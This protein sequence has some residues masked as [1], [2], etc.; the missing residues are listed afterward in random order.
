MAETRSD[1]LLTTREVAELFRVNP[2]T[3]T[4]WARRGVIQSFRTPGGNHR[5][6]RESDVRAALA[7]AASEG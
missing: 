6:F 7:A 5:R 3:V 2:R 4:T 1:R